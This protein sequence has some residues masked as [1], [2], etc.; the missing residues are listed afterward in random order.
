MG[1]LLTIGIPTFNRSWYLERL[2]GNLFQQGVASCQDVE[3][4][5]CDNA[6]TDDTEGVVGD[7]T[8]KLFQIRYYKSNANNGPDSNILKTFSLA[9]GKYVWIIG[10]DDLLAENFLQALLNEIRT[11]EYSVIHLGFKWFVSMPQKLNFGSLRFIKYKNAYAFEKILTLHS[12]FISS[13]I[14]NKSVLDSRNENTYKASLGTGLMQM[15]FICDALAKGGPYLYV[16]GLVIYAQAENS[17]YYDKWEVFIKNLY[18]F[19]ED[20]NL[21]KNFKKELISYSLRMRV[22]YLIMENEIN[23]LKIIDTFPNKKINIEFEILY[24]TIIYLKN[25]KYIG[26]LTTKLILKALGLYE[27]FRVYYYVYIYKRGS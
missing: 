8:R 27:N 4:V 26:R 22:P 3:I 18:K 17:N 19:I 12:T 6:S 24:R 7:Y 20:N 14:Y 10:D 25:N 21:T 23:I 16:R 5:I 11:S 15:H 13:N 1:K 9:K 2:L